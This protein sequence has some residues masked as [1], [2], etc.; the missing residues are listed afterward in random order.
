MSRA[1]DALRA[2]TSVQSDGSRLV[3][4]VAARLDADLA[5]VVADKLRTMGYIVIEPGPGGISSSMARLNAAGYTVHPPGETCAL[6]PVVPAA[7]RS[8]PSTSAKAAERARPTARSQAY[9]LLGAYGLVSQMP[10]AD[11]MTSDEAGAVA[12]GRGTD[13]RQ[14]WRRVSDLHAHGLIESIP[15]GPELTAPPMTRP[16]DSGREQTVYRITQ[17]GLDY[18]AAA[19]P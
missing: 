16:G 12:R 17:A 18:L 9:A 3:K 2:A 13:V 6:P 1:A 10:Q 8:D 4:A 15:D 14:P 19:K 7:R 5:P 11:G